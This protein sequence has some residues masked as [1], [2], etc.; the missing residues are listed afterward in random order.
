MGPLNEF[1]AT[2]SDS[3]AQP[4]KAMLPRTYSEGYGGSP[5]AF[6]NLLLTDPEGLG[7]ECGARPIGAEDGTACAYAAVRPLPCVCPTPKGS[8]LLTAMA[9]AVPHGMFHHRHRFFRCHLCILHWILHWSELWRQMPLLLQA[10]RTS[11]LRRAK[12]N[13]RL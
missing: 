10:V 13:T 11:Q 12:T 5:R 2:F 4:L 8:Y 3:F 1:S 9:A 6:F 7:E